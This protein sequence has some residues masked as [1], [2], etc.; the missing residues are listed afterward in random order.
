MKVFMAGNISWLEFEPIKIPK[1]DQEAKEY[2]INI[3]GW[4]L[5]NSFEEFRKAIPNEDL[6]FEQLGPIHKAVLERSTAFIYSTIDI[7]TANEPSLEEKILAKAAAAGAI[8]M[9]RSLAKYTFYSFWYFHDCSTTLDF[10]TSQVFD[11]PDCVAFGVNNEIYTA[12][13]ACKNTILSRSFVNTWRVFTRKM[14]EILET[15][16][17]LDKLFGIK[18][19]HKDD[20]SLKKNKSNR[21]ERAIIFV[22]EARAT[23]DLPKKIAMY[24]ASLECLFTTKNEEVT[25]K[26]SER[27]ACYIEATPESKM[28]TFYIIKK[29]YGIRSSYMHGKDVSLNRE[30]LID[31]SVSIDEMLR[32]TLNKI[33][34]NH[35]EF[36]L[37]DPKDKTFPGKGSKAKPQFV[38][39]LDSLFDK[40]VFGIPW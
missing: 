17:L 2:T 26:V 35:I 15:N 5:C 19:G 1:T 6:Y 24:V 38:E 25:H 9:M 11:Y 33:I 22:N 23:A 13:G 29:A 28:S 20:S 4:T 18:M 3:D 16:F 21:I 8:S 32:V 10:A 31:I 34:N 7:Q 39:G 30:I 40:L 37:R 12:S 27:C 14:E 36:F